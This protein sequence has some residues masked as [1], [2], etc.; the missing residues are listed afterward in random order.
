MEHC[1]ICK[2]GAYGD[3]YTGLT[4]TGEKFILCKPCINNYEWLKSHLADLENKVKELEQRISNHTGTRT[5]ENSRDVI[6]IQEHLES[7]LENLN[8]EYTIYD[9]ITELAR[10]LDHWKKQQG[11]ASINPFTPFR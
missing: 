10:I 6:S 1:Y 11:E 7:K 9:H 2:Q 5:G 3:N 4:I 8:R